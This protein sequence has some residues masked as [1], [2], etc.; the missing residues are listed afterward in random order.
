MT[1]SLTWNRWPGMDAE[2]ACARLSASLPPAV[3]LLGPGSREAGERLW[4]AHG[5]PYGQVV[6]WLGA[7]EARAVREAAWVLPPSGFKV[8]FICLDRSSAQAQNILLKTLEEPPDSARFLLS[9]AAPPLETVISRCVVLAV[10]TAAAV[11]DARVR[12]SVSTAVRA[13]QAG[14]AALLEQALRGWEPAHAAELRAWAAEAAAGRWRSF[15]DGFAPGVTARQALAVL[16]VLSSFEGART[17]AVVAL[18]RAFRRRLRRLHG[19]GLPM[20]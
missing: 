10:G 3:L 16:S 19:R 11:P 14:Q 7:E 17:A 1:F 12:A 6:T 4:E 15:D 9:A 18:E 2:A 20:N 5:G 8:F 13:A